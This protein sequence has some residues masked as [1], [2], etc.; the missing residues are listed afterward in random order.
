M[1]GPF[2]FFFFFDKGT[3]GEAPTVL[4]SLM[5][6]IYKYKRRLKQA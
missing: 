5:E 6:N 3:V 4:F 1:P 2:F